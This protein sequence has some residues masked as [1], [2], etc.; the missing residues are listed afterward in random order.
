MGLCEKCDGCLHAENLGTEC[1][2]SLARGT[3]Q[4]FRHHKTAIRMLRIRDHS[5]TQGRQD[6]EAMLLRAT[7]ESG[8][9]GAVPKR[10]NHQRVGG[11]EELVH[12]GTSMPERKSRQKMLQ[13][14][15]AYLV[16]CKL[17]NS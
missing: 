7:S 12:E 13:D 4:G 16:Q 6:L 5:H 8:T 17:A 1:V 10:V 3:L 15:T 14:S 2:P 9:D 11:F